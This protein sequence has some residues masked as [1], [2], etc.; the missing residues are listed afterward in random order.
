[1]KLKA[2]VLIVLV[3]ALFWALGEWDS[4]VVEEGNQVN[5]SSDT[6][7][8][9][10]TRKPVVT[11]SGYSIG[12]TV[13]FQ[14]GQAITITES[15]YMYSDWQEKTI[16]YIDFMVENEGSE[17]GKVSCG[18]FSVYADNK[19]VEQVTETDS[20]TITSLDPGRVVQGRIY[21]DL[22]PE[23][24]RDIE[25]QVGDAVWV[26]QGLGSG[27]EI[28]VDGVRVE[29]PEEL[30]YSAEWLDNEG[31]FVNTASTS[32]MELDFYDEPDDSVLGQ[33]KISDENHALN[34]EGEFV[35]LFQNVYYLVHDGN[36]QVL[37]SFYE[38]NMNDV[39]YTEGLLFVDGV[40]V[41]FYYR[42][43]E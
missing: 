10:T 22:N 28:K 33:M 4:D 24:V 14:N 30:Y 23:N 2:A 21:V 15:G 31:I 39:H 5:I 7:N 18:S 20:F 3:I 37:V 34:Y 27:T 11:K 26:I 38:Y 43:E 25:V 17:A 1:M 36:E 32:I 6:Q 41:D 35:L 9:V 29:I 13:H 19:A 42:S 40:L 12:E 16:M 8:T